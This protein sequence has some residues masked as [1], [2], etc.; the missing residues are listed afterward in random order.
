MDHIAPEDLA[1]LALDGEEPTGEMRAHLDACEECRSEFEAMQRT[2]SLGRGLRGADLEVP[3]PS[4]WSGIHAELDLDP[5]LAGDPIPERNRPD[6]QAQVRPL[7]P[8]VQNEP[9]G[10]GTSRHRNRAWWPIAVAAAVTGVLVGVGLTFAF[11]RL[12][13]GDTD[14]ASQVLA[15]AQLDAFPGWSAS[16]T[17]TVE[18]DSDGN[19]S[20]VVDLDATIPP[21]DVREVWLI[22]ADASGLVSL[23]LLDGDSGR[24]SI[25]QNIDLDEYTLVDVS[26]EPVDGQPAHSGD[27]IVRGELTRRA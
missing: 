18:A 5:A 21:G 6:L 4:V 3:P 8:K 15:T 12:G 14:S 11:A 10:A 27:S 23:G 7:A 17:A 2:V 20:V 22:R 26:A 24:F 1:V 16:G 19:R 25:P 9:S 13:A